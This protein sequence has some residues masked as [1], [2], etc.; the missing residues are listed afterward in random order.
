MLHKKRDLLT[1]YVYLQ[2]DKRNPI[3]N[4]GGEKGTKTKAECRYIDW[5]NQ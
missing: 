1:D 4:L 5:K 3:I 2:K